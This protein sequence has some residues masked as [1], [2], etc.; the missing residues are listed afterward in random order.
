M[1]TLAD[2]GGLVIFIFALAAGV[3]EEDAARNSVFAYISPDQI[4]IYSLTPC[5]IVWIKVDM[6]AV[7]IVALDVLSFAVVIFLA[8]MAVGTEIDLILLAGSNFYAASIGTQDEPVSAA[9]VSEII[10]AIYC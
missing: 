2:T 8:G 6:G 4:S 7:T 3:T 9:E 5:R 10:L 1:T